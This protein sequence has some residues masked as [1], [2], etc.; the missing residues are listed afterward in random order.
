MTSLLS[1][2]GLARASARRPWIVIG[3]WV[4][5]LVLSGLAAAFLL[6]GALTSEITFTNTPDSVRGF[7]LLD[8]RMV[9][10][11]PTTGQVTT[12]AQPASETIIVRSETTT[13]DDPI[14]QDRVQGTT[15]AIRAVPGIA[16]AQSFLDAGGPGAPAAAGLISADRHATLIPVTFAGVLEDAADRFQPYVDSLEAQ[17]VD[18][19]QVLTVGDLSI[20]DQFNTVA[21]ED[22][23]TAEVFGLPIALL[24]LVVVFGALVAAGIPV[25]L[26][27]ISIAIA[28]GLTALVGQVIELSFFVVNM[29]T[30]IGLAVGIDYTLF[31]VERYRE[32]RRRGVAKHQAIETAGATASKAVLFSGITVVLALTG[33][34]LIPTTIFF[35]LGMGA[36]L[37]VVV[38]VLATLTLIPAMLSLLGDKIDWP[39]HRRY[40]ASTAAAQA[41]AD[42]ETYHRGFW[43]RTTRVVMER[44]AMFA[45]VAVVL[46]AALSLPYFGLERGQAGIATFPD[47]DVKTAFAILNRDFAAGRLAPVEVVV[48]GPRSNAA[49]TGAVQNLTAALEQNPNIGAGAV[50]TTWNDAGDLALIKATLKMDGN[51]PE[52]F[53]MIDQLRTDIVPETFSG[54]PARAFVTGETAFNADFF[55]VVDDWTPIVFAFVL[56]LSFLLLLLVF[57]SIVI[58]IK[59]IIL[60][61]LSVGAAYGLMVLVFQD[62]VGADLLGFQQTPTIEAWV[63]IFLFCVLFG[64]SMDYHVFLLSRIKEHYDQ[65]KRNAESVAVGL[66]ATA[67]IITGAALIMVVVFSGFAMGKLVMF[68][69]MGFGLAVAVLL[70]ATVVRSVLVPAGMALLGDWNWYLPSW[71]KWLPNLNIEGSRPPALVPP[72]LPEGAS[73]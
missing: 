33:M 35:S 47:S 48:D 39:R 9:V 5:T 53:S 6:G 4:L 43:G 56:G 46:L 58:P 64:L 3:A 30:M 57:R 54:V 44:P 37:A 61:L 34:L 60:N 66:Q 16:R 36:I 25:A 24:I 8:E 7:D 42:H 72:V 20:D 13:V 55:Q 22:L 11:D 26:A 29:I 62:G 65:T 21:E 12:N 41:N 50:Q 32:E 63:P 51:A 59:A 67:R 69:Q 27:L 31:I 2:G 17:R 71:L 15:D 38:A 18:D 49:V 70:D 10:T 14:F 28:V 23:Q 52:A 1:T 73:D 45:A 68:Q 40:D 19:F